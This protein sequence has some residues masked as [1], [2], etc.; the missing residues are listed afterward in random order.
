MWPLWSMT[1]SAS[2]CQR[3]GPYAEAAVVTADTTTDRRGHNRQHQ[4]QSWE[5]QERVTLY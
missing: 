4:R 3:R 1:A 5:A 2:N